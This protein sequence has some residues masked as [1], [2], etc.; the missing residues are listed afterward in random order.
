MVWTLADY[1]NTTLDESNKI[2]D[3]STG[4]QG[5]VTYEKNLALM[6]ANANNEVKELQRR[7]RGRVAYNTDSCMVQPLY[8]KWNA[9]NAYSCGSASRQFELPIMDKY[10]PGAYTQLPVTFEKIP[11]L[12]PSKDKVDKKYLDIRTSPKNIVN[13]LRGIVY[14]LKH[15]K[16]LPTMNNQLSTKGSTAKTLQFVFGRENRP[17]YLILLLSVVLLCV[18]IISGVASLRRGVMGGGTIRGG[19]MP[20]FVV[21]QPYPGMAGGSYGPRP[22]RSFASGRRFFH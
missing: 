8:P 18:S 20:Q 5:V 6:Q 11:K 19:S 7:A 9:E 3:I 15:W 4:H 10:S 2:N 1:A 21:M 12:P 17:M 13:T 14:D 16:K 22:L